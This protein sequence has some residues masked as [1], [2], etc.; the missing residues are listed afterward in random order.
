MTV[1]TKVNRQPVLI[2]RYRAIHAKPGTLAPD[3]PK[4]PTGLFMSAV[5]GSSLDRGTGRGLHAR[6]T[7][8][9]RRQTRQRMR[10]IK[11]T[12][13]GLY[14]RT[15]APV[16]TG[17]RRVEFTLLKKQKRKKKRARPRQTRQTDKRK[18]PHHRTRPKTGDAALDRNH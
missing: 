15:E 5:R 17:E 1:W 18:R 7:R 8:A 2:H 13:H 11:H 4:S 10:A 3:L 16:K 6:N 12:T 14:R 9:S